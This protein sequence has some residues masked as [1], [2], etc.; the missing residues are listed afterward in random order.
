M[1]RH[2]RLDKF[3]GYRCRRGKLIGEGGWAR[4]STN[5]VSERFAYCPVERRKSCEAISGRRD[6]RTAHVCRVGTSRP[7]QQG[8]ESSARAFPTFFGHAQGFFHGDSRQARHD[9][10]LFRMARDRP[11]LH[12]DD[13]LTDHDGHRRVRGRRYQRG[14]HAEEH[15]AVVSHAGRWSM[16]SRCALPDSA[17]LHLSGSRL[18]GAIRLESMLGGRRRA[19]RADAWI[20]LPVE[21]AMRSICVE[22]SSPIRCSRIASHVRLRA[23]RFSG[24]WAPSH[25]DAFERRG[26]SATR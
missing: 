14:E 23:D 4:L 24:I 22:K 20:Y 18:A 17:M 3:I 21:N 12:D 1:S 8:R 25:E 26:G 9:R 11:I 2:H 13:T 6:G 5:T 10:R 15:E 7:S 19:S 16:C